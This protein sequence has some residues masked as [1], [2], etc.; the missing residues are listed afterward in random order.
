M[1]KVNGSVIVVLMQAPLLDQS[2]LGSFALCDYLVYNGVVVVLT[3]MFLM[4]KLWIF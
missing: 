1:I 3:I 4:L 2:L